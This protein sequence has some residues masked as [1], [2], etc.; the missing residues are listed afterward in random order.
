M[1]DQQ[2][3]S[4]GP[5]FAAG[6]PF[7]SLADGRAV[8]GHVGEDPVILIRRAD[9]V[10]AIGASCTHYGGPLDE[11]LVV[12]DTVRCPWH[13]ACFDLKSGDALR[14]P[15]LNPVSRW[16]VEHRGD[17][18][19][20]GEKL[21][22]VERPKL[23]GR[24]PERVVI[25]GGGAAGGAAASKLRREGFARSITMISADTSAPYDRPN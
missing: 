1:S 4:A 23:G 19:Y 15:A 10:F 20:V 7:S 16:K 12:G 5:D 8:R 9:Q 11:G 14:S 18:V 21:P 24:L 17:R 2:G 3:K 22:P 6:I 13:H 25:I